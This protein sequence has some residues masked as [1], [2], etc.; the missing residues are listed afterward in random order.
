MPAAGQASLTG[1]YELASNTGVPELTPP[2]TSTSPVA[3]ATA[4][5]QNR[6]TGSDAV[7]RQA[8]IPGS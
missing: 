3:R 7:D 8:F 2:K 6:T 1:G 4:E 5:C